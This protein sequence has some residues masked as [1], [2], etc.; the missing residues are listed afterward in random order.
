MGGVG[1]LNRYR[2]TRY[3]FPFALTAS[4]LAGCSFGD[5]GAEKRAEPVTLK[6]MYYD[7][8]SFF[9]QYGM[10]F[11]ALHPEVEIEVVNTQSIKHEPGKDMEAETRKF[12]EEQKPDIVMLSAD[13]Y[14]KMANEG[15]LLELET[16]VQ[17]KS[18]DQAGLMPGMLD[19]LKELSGG[20]LYGLVPN[21]YSQAIFY[22]KDMFQKYGVELPKDQMSWDD[23]FRLAAMFPTTGSKDDRVYGLKMGYSATD[24]YQLGNMIGLT[25]N[26]NIVDAGAKNVTVNTD[27]WKKTYETALNAWKSGALYTEDPN[28]MSD[29][30][31]QYEDYLL[32]DP[33]IGG[34]VAMTFEGTYLM[35]QIKQAQNVV[36]DKAVKNWDIVTMPVDPGNPEYSPYVSFNNIFA[37][38]AKSAQSKAAW[39]FLQYIHGDEFAR[40]TSKRQMGNMP[41]RT[42]YLSDKE[43]HHFEAFYKLKPIQPAM[44]KNYEAVPGD[45]MNNFQ[46]MAQQELSAAADGKVSVSEALDSLQTKAEEALLLAKQQKDTAK[47][48]ETATTESG[49]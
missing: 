42:Q 7:E 15:K 19:Y 3:V 13:Q 34:K 21:F 8:R 28:Q 17:E 23:L 14:T 49:G 18:F 1:K 24:L 11:S 32:R 4:L 12:I 46:G 38:S 36:K 31:M 48:G 29:G 27:A 33:F 40:V 25:K 45:F 47:P 9:D 2:W 39:T 10:L 22:N 35:D 30:P 5:A 44:Y 20:K 26:L 6:V 37:I 41:V 43:G 16:Q